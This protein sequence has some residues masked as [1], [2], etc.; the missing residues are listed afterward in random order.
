M[1]LRKFINKFFYFLIIMLIAI[2]SCTDESIREYTSIFSVNLETKIVTKRCDLGYGYEIN[3][4]AMENYF[5]SPDMK[6]FISIDKDISEGFWIF[7]LRDINSNIIIN[8]IITLAEGE[9]PTPDINFSYQGD[10]IIFSMDFV[11]CVNVDGSQEKKLSIGSYP[12]FSPN[13]KNILF[14]DENGYLTLYDLEQNNYVELYYE[15]HIE[16]PVFHPNGEKIYFFNDSDLKTFNLSDSSIGVVAE[17]LFFSGPIQFSNSGDRKVFCIAMKVFTLDENDSINGLA[18]HSS[19][20]CIAGDG[21]K[22]AIAEGS[23][24]IVDFNG[25]NYIELGLAINNPGIGFSPDDKEVYYINTWK[26]E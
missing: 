9:P 2:T 25:T 15:D 7:N 11:Y 26:D 4:S 19:N 3:Y 6:Y 21:T 22:I 16:Y 24:K 14:L 10:K 13:G 17:D 20:P 8:E 1:F 23:L 5:F 12:T 18:F